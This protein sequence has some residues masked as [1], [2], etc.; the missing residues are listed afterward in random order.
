MLTATSAAIGRAW[1]AWRRWFYTDPR[2]PA[3]AAITAEYEAAW[4]AAMAAVPA[5]LKELKAKLFMLEWRAQGYLFGDPTVGHVAAHE[6]IRLARQ[7]ARDRA[8]DLAAK[9]R[10]AASAGNTRSYWRHWSPS[11]FFQA[12]LASMP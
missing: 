8:P 5:T 3:Y 4:N 10:L 11:V 6:C 7:A 2:D 12:M 9:V 1:S